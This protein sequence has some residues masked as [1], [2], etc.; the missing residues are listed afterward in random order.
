MKHVWRTGIPSSTLKVPM[1][2]LTGDGFMGLAMG[3]V[4]VALA[5]SFPYSTLKTSP[6]YANRMKVLW[7]YNMSYVQLDMPKY[8][9]T[10]L[11][12]ALG[13]LANPS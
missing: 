3:L 11:D 13:V 7:N 8:A 9:P 1:T 5:F 6:H 10:N 12:P 2:D 4:S